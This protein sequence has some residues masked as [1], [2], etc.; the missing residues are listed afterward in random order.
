MPPYLL[1]CQE[2]KNQGRTPSEVL[3]LMRQ[4]GLTIIEA[5]KAFMTLYEVSLAEAKQKLTESP[6]WQDI[7]RAAEPL[8]DQLAASNHRETVNGKQ[9]S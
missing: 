5:I 7:I 6:F 3:R 1:E 4:R 2:A 8:H 9:Q